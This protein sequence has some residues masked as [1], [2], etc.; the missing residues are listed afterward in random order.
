MDPKTMYSP[1][2]TY[3]YTIFGFH[4]H[5]LFP[6]NSLHFSPFGLFNLILV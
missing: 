2:F 3:V 5:L 4:N 6:R 1:V